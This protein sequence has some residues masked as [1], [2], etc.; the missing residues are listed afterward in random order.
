MGC[1][2]ARPPAN[3]INRAANLMVMGFGW[4]AAGRGKGV[5]GGVL[6]RP[7][8][9][10]SCRPRAALPAPDPSATA[11]SRWAPKETS[12]KAHYVNSCED[13]KKGP[14]SG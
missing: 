13:L 14:D 12:D 4:G 11:P 6:F 8:A 7:Q 2:Q 10:E 5:A 1:D 9:G 3:A